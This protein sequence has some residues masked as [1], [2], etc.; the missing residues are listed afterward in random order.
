MFTDDMIEIDSPIFADA[1]YQFECELIV[2]ARDGSGH[3]LITDVTRE[4]FLKLQKNPS[5]ESL[6]ALA[7]GRFCQF[8]N[9]Y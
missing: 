7:N 5:H 8:I 1:E 2:F 9:S 3:W 4:D 6:V